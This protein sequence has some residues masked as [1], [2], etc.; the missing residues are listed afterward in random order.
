ML[1]GGNNQ[2]VGI[3][4]WAGEVKKMLCEPGFAY[5]WNRLLDC[6]YIKYY[7]DYMILFQTVYLQ[8]RKHPISFRKIFK[9]YPKH[10]K[11]RIALSRLRCSAHKLMAEEGIFRNIERRM[12]LCPFCNMN[13][14][15]DEFHFVLVCPAFRDLRKDILPIYYCTWPTTTNF[16]K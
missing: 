9:M 1:E 7:N 2:P 6:N 3:L 12:R 10:N 8:N 11:H 4:S 5:L 14:V 13:M 16:V 15:E